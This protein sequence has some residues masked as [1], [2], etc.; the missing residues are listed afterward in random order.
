MVYATIKRPKADRITVN[1]WGFLPS[2]P[3]I[4]ILDVVMG[5]GDCFVIK[6]NK[7]MG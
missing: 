6:N 7:L 3:D 5:A 2:L 4:D 1:E